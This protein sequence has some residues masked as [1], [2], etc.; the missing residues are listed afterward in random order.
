[1]SQFFDM[2][3]KFPYELLMIFESWV[4]YELVHLKFF[5]FLLLGL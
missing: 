2:I 5:D 4:N 1:M 3:A